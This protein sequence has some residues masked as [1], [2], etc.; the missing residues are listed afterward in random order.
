MERQ[1]AFTLLFYYGTFLILC[2]IASVIFIGMKAKTALISGSV[3]GIAAMS[4]GHLISTGAN[5]GFWGGVL[6]S[7][8]LFCVFSWRSTKTLFAIFELIP[9]RHEDLR[10]KGVAFLIIS[11]M[12]VVSIMVCFLLLLNA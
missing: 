12:A 4:L 8:V 6:L 5:A 10:G 9:S 1:A 11:L 7:L 3:S 2:G